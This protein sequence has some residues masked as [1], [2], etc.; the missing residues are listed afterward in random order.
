MIK[1]MQQVF[2]V[3]CLISAHEQSSQRLKEQTMIK[4]MQQVQVYVA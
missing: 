2:S 1:L 3:C 4:L